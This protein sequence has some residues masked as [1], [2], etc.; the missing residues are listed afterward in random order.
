MKSKAGAIARALSL[1]LVSS[2]LISF[3]ATS[4]SAQIKAGVTCKKTGEVRAV[5]TKQFVCKRSGKKLI[6]TQVL[7]AKQPAPSQ[8]PTPTPTPT[9][10]PTP[11]PSPTPT[12]KPTPLPT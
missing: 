1:I 6:W 5:G 3:P 7:E 11:T 9:P 8:S 4:N 2:T 12:Q 10:R